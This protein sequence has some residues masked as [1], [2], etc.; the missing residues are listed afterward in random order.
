M[1]SAT[2]MARG[3]QKMIETPSG[4]RQAAPM[5]ITPSVIPA[6]FQFRSERCAGGESV[7]GMAGER[8]IFEAACRPEI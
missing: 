4:M 2:T 1:T 8:S 6:V 3:S 5:T 7:S